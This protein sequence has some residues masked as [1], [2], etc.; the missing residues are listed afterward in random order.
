MESKLKDIA[1]NINL[2]LFTYNGDECEGYV[3]RTAN[4]FHYDDMDANIAKFV[5]KNH[6]KTDKHWSKS[7]IIK[8]ELQ[9]VNI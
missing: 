6:I 9:D 5:R 7:E 4:S 2:K 1:K 8:N 3:I